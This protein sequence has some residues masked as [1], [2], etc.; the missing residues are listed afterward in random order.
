MARKIN[1]KIRIEFVIE[2]TEEEYQTCVCAAWEKAYNEVISP[3]D[4][5]PTTDRLL[6][7]DTDI[8][9]MLAG[10][11]FGEIVHEASREMKIRVL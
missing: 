7:A 6:V 3:E 9:N 10:S 1:K 8:D 11:C 4:L 2:T 5:R